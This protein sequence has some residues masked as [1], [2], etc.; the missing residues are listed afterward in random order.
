M[1]KRSLLSR[2]VLFSVGAAL[3]VNLLVY[4]GGKLLSRGALH[5]SLELAL[6]R[7]IPL[8]PWMVLFY[9]LGFVFWIVNYSLSIALE[10]GGRG[11]FLAAHVLGELVC[12]LF[13]VLLPTTMTRP[14]VTGRGPASALLRLTYLLDS[15]DN[16]FPSIHCLASW[17]SWIGVRGDKRVPF[18]YR[19]LTLALTLAVCASTLTVKQHVALDAAAGILL[20]ELSYLAAGIVPKLRKKAAPKETETAGE[21]EKV[22]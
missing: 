18:W 1:T 11:R 22:G 7:A 5:R 8:L 16:L 9:W 4:Y 10:K 14:E 19:A 15:P 3:V 12:F 20:A 21:E 17:L 6:D 2:R 13:F